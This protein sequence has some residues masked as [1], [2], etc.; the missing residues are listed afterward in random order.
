MD[1]SDG[2]VMLT[3]GH[4]AGYP[5]GYTQDQVEGNNSFLLYISTCY[6]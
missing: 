3:M 2:G 1:T 6:M 4:G 5:A